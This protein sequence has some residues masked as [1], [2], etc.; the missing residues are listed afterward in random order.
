MRSDGIMIF[1]IIIKGC[2]RILHPLQEALLAVL[3]FHEQGSNKFIYVFILL[4]SKTLMSIT[5]MYISITN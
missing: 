1:W 2:S 4:I 5:L 3:L